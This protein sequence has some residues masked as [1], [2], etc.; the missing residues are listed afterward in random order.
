EEEQKPM[1]VAVADGIS[2]NPNPNPEKSTRVTEHQSQA[3][4]GPKAAG[5]DGSTTPV[6]SPALA[7]GRAGR[8]APPPNPQPDQAATSASAGPGDW[9]LSPQSDPGGEDDGDVL[10]LVSPE[11]AEAL[12]RDHYEECADGSLKVCCPAHDDH[13]PSLHVSVKGGK[14]LFHD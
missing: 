5:V 10:D 8:Q 1:V 12:T 3:P 4:E 11:L 13:T 7:G 2:T 6:A 14:V 9:E